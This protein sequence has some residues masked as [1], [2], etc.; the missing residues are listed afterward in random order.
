MKQYKLTSLFAFILSVLIV[1]PVSAFA[2]Y[3]RHKTLER[4]F[5]VD[6]NHQLKISNKYGKVQLINWDR[7]EIKITVRVTAKESSAQRAETALDRVHI[8]ESNQNKV[9]EFVTNIDS[10]PNN[11]WSFSSSNSSLSID[12]QIHLPKSNTISIQNRYGATEIADR[13]GATT[14]SIGY[15]TLT[16]GR[17][18]G[19]TNTISISYSQAKIT[20]VSTASASVKYSKLDL[21]TASKLKLKLSYSSGSKIDIVNNELDASVSYS[22]K[23]R[24]GLGSKI[25]KTAIKASYSGVEIQTAPGAAFDFDISARYGQFDYDSKK[26]TIR[27]QTSGNTSKSFS[28]SW[29]KGGGGTLRVESAYGNVSLK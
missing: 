3:E 25:Q 16:A 9:I 18:M 17:L 10:A 26:T 2:D 13:D 27:N 14:L 29:N 12:Y 11:W 22:G 20:A 19:N 24:V 1:A 28:G 21:G 6:N 23:F 5:R 7:P 15:G 8:I 4:S